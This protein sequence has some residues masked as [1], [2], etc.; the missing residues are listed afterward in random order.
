ECENAKRELSKRS[1]VPINVYY[2]GK[3]LT[4]ALTRSDFERMAGDLMLRT[5]TTSELVMQQAGIGKGELDEV[6]LVGGSTHMPVVKQMLR[7]VTGQEPSHELV[8]EEAVAQ[9]AA[10]HAAI[11]EA[12]TSGAESRMGETILK[13]LRAVNTSDVNSH[14]LGVKITDPENRTR[15]I[16]HVM[17]PRNTPIPHSASQRFVTNTPN[18]QRIH[19]YVLEGDAPDPDACEAIG[20]FR[21]ADLPPNLPAGAPVEVTYSYNSSGRISARAKELTGGRQAT[22]EIVREGRLDDN[23]LEAFETLAKEYRVE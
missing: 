4:V 6:L 15:K 13:R 17:I 19:V 20:D 18:Q 14:S 8:P 1:Q 21:V 23:G 16:N 7:E 9:G 5:K 12:R 22:T 2:K 11:L 10:I 3:T